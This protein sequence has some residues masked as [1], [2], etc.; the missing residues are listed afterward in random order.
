M[1]FAIQARLKVW[2]PKA[3]VMRWGEKGSKETE[4]SWATVYRSFNKGDFRRGTQPGLCVHLVSPW[5]AKQQGFRKSFWRHLSLSHLCTTFYFSKNT[6]LHSCAN[7]GWWH[8]SSFLPAPSSATQCVRGTISLSA[9]API[10]IPYL[11]PTLGQ[12]NENNL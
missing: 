6:I 9:L 1:P 3:N 2:F 5:W 4:A 10:A 11:F 7:L 12:R 8:A